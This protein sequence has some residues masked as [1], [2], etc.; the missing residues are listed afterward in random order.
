MFI[1]S[2]LFSVVLACVCLYSQAQELT[3]YTIPSPYGINWES[4]A[5]LLK[6]FIKNSTSKS[7]NGTSNF[8][9]GHMMVELKHNNQYALVGT[10][11]RS[12][13]EMINNVLMNGYGLGILFASIPGKLQEKEENEIYVKEKIEEGRI[14][15]ITYKIN[16]HVFDR[17]WT[18]LEGYKEKSYYK[19]YNGK[20]LPR[21]GKGA[22][23]SAFAM[24]FVEVGGLMDLFP[25]KDW[26]VH[27]KAPQ[28]LIGGPPGLN[29]E[30]GLEEIFFRNSWVKNKREGYQNICYYEPSLLYNFIGQ[31]WDSHTD[32]PLIKK[33]NKGKA[34]GFIIDAT[35]KT[36][37]A[38]A[39]WQD[40]AYP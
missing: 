14:A 36:C 31:M 35:D 23:C 2:L 18:Y 39:I 21:Q 10:S 1:R 22:G 33:Y 9:I 17:L 12:K 38:E 16:L 30:V 15:F 26:F 8:A 20:N 34:K 25:T 13:V 19:I 5:K 4:P 28:Y 24:S 32:T 6:S 27:V 7:P 29:R 11:A 37:P 3:L 40:Q